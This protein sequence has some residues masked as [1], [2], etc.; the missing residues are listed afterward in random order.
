MTGAAAEIWYYGKR[1]IGKCQMPKML[2]ACAK[3]MGLGNWEEF[4]GRAIRRWGITKLSNDKNVSTGESMA[5]ARH[6]SI[7]QHWKYISN[8]HDSEMM[9]LQA[10]GFAN[11]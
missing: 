10:M 8:D 9:R 11:F 5:A 6:E 2:K 3:R 7:G 4:S 1:P